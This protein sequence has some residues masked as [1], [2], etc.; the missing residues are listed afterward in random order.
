[1]AN[2]RPPLK[3]AL[4]SLPFPNNNIDLADLSMVTDRGGG[5]IAFPRFLAL[6]ALQKLYGFVGTPPQILWICGYPPANSMDLRVPPRKFRAKWIRNHPPTHE[7][8]GGY[9]QIRG[10]G[11]WVHLNLGYLRTGCMK[12]RWSCG[13]GKGTKNRGK[14]MC[15]PP[16]S[17]TIG[18]PTH[19]GGKGEKTP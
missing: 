14:A 16:R 19:T 11:V 9:P 10:F 3:C 15:P 17:V 2:V 6:I 18:M 8:A 12:I 7:F 4:L 1:M 13:W 5:H